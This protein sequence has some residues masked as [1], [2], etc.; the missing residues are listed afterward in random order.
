[1][2]KKPHINVAVVP[3]CGRWI[4][5]RWIA[6]SF[7]ALHTK[8]HWYLCIYNQWF[9]WFCR[10]Q[11]PVCRSEI[12]PPSRWLYGR[13]NSQTAQGFLKMKRLPRWGPA[14][15]AASSSRPLASILT[16]TYQKLHFLGCCR[17][18]YNHLR[19]VWVCPKIA[20]H[21]TL[22]SGWD[23]RWSKVFYIDTTSLEN[24]EL[25]LLGVSH[26]FRITKNASPDQIHLKEV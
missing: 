8:T 9:W 21:V 6:P 16:Q 2:W 25:V 17:P 19:D 20:L 23:T 18:T 1:M 13:V 11:I 12:A 24:R 26:P 22:F 3:R 14:R 7:G 4:A 5:T 15:P 10:S